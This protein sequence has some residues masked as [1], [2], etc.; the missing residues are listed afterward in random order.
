MTYGIYVLTTRFENTINGMI[1]SWV[2]QVS[3]EPPLFMVA[4]HP[5]R[6]SHDLLS[7]S[8]YFALHILSKK[9]KDLIERFKGPDA[10]EKFASLPWKD[11]VTGCPILGDCIGCLECFTTQSIR[12]GNHTI[13]FG[14]VV[15][16]VFNGGEAPLCTLDYESSYLGKA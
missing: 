11:G 2:S 7:Q 14:E 5:N 4:V 6:Y 9:K 15:H 10:A 1:V 13:F 8:G 16:A 3:Y 12:P